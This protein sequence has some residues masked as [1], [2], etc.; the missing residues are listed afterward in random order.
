MVLR[1]F[2]TTLPNVYRHL[3]KRPCFCDYLMQ[4]GIFTNPRLDRDHHRLYDQ[5]LN[6]YL[7]RYA[8][9]QLFGQC[10]NPNAETEYSFGLEEADQ[11]GLSLAALKDGK[12]RGRRAPICDI[13]SCT[14][15]REGQDEAPHPGCK[16][17]FEYRG[18]DDDG[19]KDGYDSEP[20]HSLTPLEASEK[21]PLGVK[22]KPIQKR[23]ARRRVAVMR[24][25]IR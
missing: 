4:T 10:F 17:K 15:S 8:Q 7:E 18:E 2:Q 16:Y 9:R 14:E 21:K 20:A 25:A 11:A 1:T 12:V 13:F 23:R 3:Q 6:Q 22:R 19:G 5:I 24:Q